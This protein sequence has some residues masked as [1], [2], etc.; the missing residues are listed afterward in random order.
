[1][2]KD[3]LLRRYV[4]MLSEAN[5]TSDYRPNAVKEFMFHNKCK[6][7][8]AKLQNAG[9][10]ARLF[11]REEYSNEN[12]ENHYNMILEF[13]EKGIINSDDL[14]YIMSI[15][16][17]MDCTN[18]LLKSNTSNSYKLAMT[19]LEKNNNAIYFYDK[20]ND[21]NGDIKLKN[22]KN[23]DVDVIAKSAIRLAINKNNVKEKNV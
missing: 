22:Y 1:M 8:L 3:R 21:F 5:H 14:K 7:A 6:K 20:T 19:G 4:W 23:I 2:K 10:S 15:D 9:M 16:R 17:F 11:M 18:Q 12:I 13:I